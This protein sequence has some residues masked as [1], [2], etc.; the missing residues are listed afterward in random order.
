MT[1]KSLLP[2]KP[3]LSYREVKRIEIEFGNYALHALGE[4]KLTAEEAAYIHLE[5]CKDNLTE[6]MPKTFQASRNPIY[7]RGLK[8]VLDARNIRRSK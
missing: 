1:K 3:P 4:G 2:P 7:R 8:G 6:G 5:W